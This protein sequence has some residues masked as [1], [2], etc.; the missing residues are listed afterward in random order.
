MK[1]SSDVSQEL[2]ELTTTFQRAAWSF[3]DADTVAHCGR[4]DV[5]APLRKVPETGRLECLP[6][7]DRDTLGPVTS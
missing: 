5:I 4:C 3:E 7:W 1:R 2:A 6:C